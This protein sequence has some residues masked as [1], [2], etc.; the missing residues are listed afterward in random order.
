MLY[1]IHGT[2]QSTSRKKL[3][4]LVEGLL[5]KKPNASEFWLDSDSLTESEIDSLIQ[6][7]GLF[8]NKY[9]V[10]LD[11]VLEYKEHQ[12]SLLKKFK[13]IS[14]SENIFIFLEG[15]LTKKILSR[16]EKWADKI[17]K[18]DLGVLPKE[19]KFNI[20]RKNINKI[21]FNHN[22]LNDGKLVGWLARNG[23]LDLN[24][25]TIQDAS[26][27]F[28]HLNSVPLILGSIIENK[29]ASAQEI[30][31]DE[32]VKE[33]LTLTKKLNQKSWHREFLNLV[34]YANKLDKVEYLDPDDP[35]KTFPKEVVGNIIQFSVVDNKN[36][37]FG[38]K[39]Q[40][41]AKKLC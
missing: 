16:F 26:I 7:S 2:D 18:F 24:G 27:R 23:L 32:D 36:L 20:L 6:S 14:K 4:A 3:H 30:L 38:K 5:K 15:K 17:Q 29:S 39:E 35:D 10:V 8:E 13:E 28:N 22:I 33:L 34:S 37:Y 1:L 9:I 19:E 11:K 41:C 25:K 12:D 21:I 40:S 31:E